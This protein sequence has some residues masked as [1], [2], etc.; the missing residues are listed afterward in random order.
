MTIRFVPP[1][2]RPDYLG[3][4]KTGLTAVADAAAQNPYTAPVRIVELIKA[5]RGTKTATPE[6]LAWSWWSQTIAFAAAEFVI[7]VRRNHLLGSGPID[8]SRRA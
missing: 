1:K 8:L 2:R 6:N 5:L 3:A 4:I 7:S